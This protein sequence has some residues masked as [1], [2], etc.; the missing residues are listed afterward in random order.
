[1]PGI[2]A[3]SVVLVR[4]NV[5]API[6]DMAKLIDRPD[7]G[8]ETLRRARQEAA[9]KKLIGFLTANR[10]SSTYLAA[11]P[12]AAIAAPLIIATGQ[13]VMAMGGYLGTDPILT[14]ESLERLV[15]EG[16]LRYVMI[17]GFTLVPGSTALAAMEAWVRA[18]GR[19]VDALEWGISRPRRNA[20]YAIPLGGRWVAVPPPELYDLAAR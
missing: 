14:P 19:K 16:K 8:R 15:V 20:P 18:H 2:T 9:R 11:V 7:P 4:P 5:A 10:R 6:A 17:G 13:P 1:L 12:N 3:A